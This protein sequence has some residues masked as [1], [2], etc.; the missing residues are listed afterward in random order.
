MTKDYVAICQEF[1]AGAKNFGGQ[2]P[3][4]VGAF[5]QL[6]TAASKPGAL[7]GKTKELMAL[8]ISITLRCEGCIAFH[9]KA[10]IK[11]GATGAEVADAIGVAMEM[12]GGP[13]FV[14][15][16]AAHE[17]YE[18]FMQAEFSSEKVG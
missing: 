2:A 8:A 10:A 6:V 15:G 17:A 18:Q 5:R 12:G 16:T 3:E 1:E 14:F 11:A 13:A 9:T 4:V 7:D